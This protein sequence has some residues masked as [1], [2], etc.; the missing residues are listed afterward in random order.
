MLLSMRSRSTIFHTHWNLAFLRSESNFPHRRGTLA[1]PP[2]GIPSHLMEIASGKFTQNQN[3][4]AMLM[5]SKRGV[6]EHLK[7]STRDTV[8]VRASSAQG[9]TSTTRQEVSNGI[10]L[11]GSIFSNGVWGNSATLSME[12]IDQGCPCSQARHVHP[13]QA[14]THLYSLLAIAQPQRLP[15]C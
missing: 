14:R 12:F 3:H 10:R 5:G 9:S 13:N 2:L 6:S 1:I 11:T 7:G 8:T 4:F 15:F